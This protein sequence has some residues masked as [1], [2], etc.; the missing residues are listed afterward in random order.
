MISMDEIIVKTGQQGI[1]PPLSP[2]EQLLLQQQLLSLLAR[3]TAHYTAGESSS[4][5]VETAERL[6][7][8]I[9]FTLHIH[10]E[11][12]SGEY[13]ALLGQDMGVLLARGIE[14]LQQK[15]ADGQA[16]WTALV[17]HLP[18]VTNIALR[19]TLQSIGTF[20]GRYDLRFLAQEIPC[21]IDYQ[22]ARPVPETLQGV[23][24]VNRYLQHLAIESD[25]L[26]RFRKEALVPL[27][28]AYCP[29]Y[30]GLLINLY[31]PAAANA[32]GLA[33]LG[34]SPEML[35]IAPEVR[36]ELEELFAHQT[37]Q[38]IRETLAAGARQLADMLAIQSPMAR[39]YLRGCTEDLA[40][41]IA[42]ARDHGGL[43]GIFLSAR[44]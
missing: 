41:R 3:Q 19:D 24:Y 35:D 31:E 21:D 39:E 16:L 14:Q 42:T 18:P 15:L 25:F 7:R 13:R 10:P 6:L 28:R 43:S 27:L 12:D 1:E 26:C 40:P 2:E 4:V 44:K 34:E 32:V 37:K 11:S 20:W 30:N 8:S 17:T 38:E 22:L 23:D 36:G 29:D 33:L 5:P 9:C